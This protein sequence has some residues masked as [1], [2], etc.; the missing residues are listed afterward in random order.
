[1]SSRICSHCGE[2]VASD[3]VFCTACGGSL[4]PAC[5]HC[6]HENQ[7][8][9]R[10]CTGC[11]GGLAA[12]NPG[13]APQTGGLGRATPGPGTLPLP[14]GPEPSAIRTGEGNDV[15]PPS[16]EVQ[17]ADTTPAVPYTEP[18][19]RASARAGPPAKRT[20]SLPPLAGDSS[21][22]P[23]IRKAH[24]PAVRRGDA[25]GRPQEHAVHDL[26]EEGKGTPIARTIPE[27]GRRSPTVSPTTDLKRIEELL[28]RGE[29]QE[30]YRLIS[31]IDRMQRGEE[32]S[33][34]LK[35]AC[36][37]WMGRLSEAERLC[38]E[39]LQKS[40]TSPTAEAILRQI[41]ELRRAQAGYLNDAEKMLLPTMERFSG[42]GNASG[43]V[44]RGKYECYHCC[45]SFNVHNPA[46][47]ISPQPY[48]NPILCPY[49]FTKNVVFCRHYGC[50]HCHG[51]LSV[52]I[53]WEG[54]Q[55]IC[56]WC[57]Q[58]F[59]RPADEA[60]THTHDRSRPFCFPG[61][62]TDPLQSTVDQEAQLEPMEFRSVEEVE[63]QLIKG[64][65]PPWTACYRGEFDVERPLTEV[66]SDYF[67]L[68]RHF[69]PAGAATLLAQHLSWITA[70]ALSVLI[71]GLD[72]AVLYPVASHFSQATFVTYFADVVAWALLLALPGRLL[73]YGVRLM[74]ARFSAVGAGL[75]TAMDKM[76]GNRTVLPGPALMLLNLCFP[77]LILVLIALTL[78]GG[79]ARAVEMFF[80]GISY[81]FVVWPVDLAMRIIDIGR[82]RKVLWDVDPD[83]GLPFDARPFY[84]DGLPVLGKLQQMSF[85]RLMEP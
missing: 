81:A 62:S 85:F 45:K 66:A 77:L 16:P 60:L 22:V 38:G 78:V 15:S 70:P 5:L 13:S 9:D 34:H 54:F 42:A 64:K 46:S 37:F 44:L 63:E 35:A 61:R 82:R 47:V 79:A 33:E 26:G 51:R 84:F 11:G 4:K 8:G 29:F 57:H 10:F 58:R 67:R 14:P 2:G 41:P 32:D 75:M 39:I 49:C 53:L 65:L 6:G 20:L 80:T 12:T 72:A 36:L 1:M 69:D 73:G 7:I 56:P 3:A 83:D 30:A 52:N 59:N 74:V 18:R 21:R 55:L 76:N 40:R 68:R 48:L 43:D 31:G 17:P 50:P 25:A 71:F 24:P 23:A 19:R 28:G 27:D